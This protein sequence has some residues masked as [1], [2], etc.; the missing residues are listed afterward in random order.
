MSRSVPTIPILADLIPDGLEY[1][2]NLLVEFEPDSL[3]FETSFAIIAYAM[4]SQI[5]ADY[6]TWTRSPEKI[7]EAL[8]R[9]DVD[10]QRLEGEDRLRIVD[11]YS[12]Q[13]G[14]NVPQKS[15]FSDSSVK[16]AD[17]S[18]AAT[19]SIKTHDETDK[20]RLHIDDNNSILAE[21]NEEKAVIQYYRTRIIPE[22]KARELAAFHSLAAGVHTDTF[23]KQFELF[24]DGI[25]DFKS[26]E[27]DGLI[28]QLVRIR[29]MRGRSY[30]SRWRK[31][32]LQ[33]NNEV[34][35]TD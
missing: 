31:L 26:Q 32:S 28:E 18:I 12:T 35:L 6:H 24:C 3:W 22:C 25:I 9:L 16:I 11:S 5:R 15:H 27:K 8:G 17:L 2:I 10:V 14:L 21:Y 1:G 20:R 13:T 29:L 4:R 34:I 30:D 33:K 7:R 19:Q 23:Y